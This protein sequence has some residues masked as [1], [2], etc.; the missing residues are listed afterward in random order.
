MKDNH[1]YL[2]HILEAI[3]RVNI[4]VQN[5]PIREDFMNDE[6]WE[7]SEVIFRQL[8]IIGEAVKSISE[9]YKMKYPN[10]PWRQ[11]ASMRDYLIHEYFTINYERVWDTVKNDIP[12][13]EK[14]VR[15][16]LDRPE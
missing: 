2:E 6:N 7:T 15:D 8:E 3:E 14:Q 16:M 4:S 9:D 13:F 12:V 10:I 5:T 11:I 1:I